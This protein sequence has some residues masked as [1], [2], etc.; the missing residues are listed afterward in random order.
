MLPEIPRPKKT[1]TRATKSKKA[2]RNLHVAGYESNEL[3]APPVR[4][5]IT[6]SGTINPKVSREA[7]TSKRKVALR[8]SDEEAGKKSDLYF[9][10]CDL[11]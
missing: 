2:P 4:Q 1:T 3:E 6:G 5:S 7:S 9:V 11:Y 10:S 8:E